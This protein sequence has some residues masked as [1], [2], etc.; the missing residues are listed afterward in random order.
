M[1]LVGVKAEV[2]IETKAN[3]NEAK[4]IKVKRQVS[5]RMRNCDIRI[6]QNRRSG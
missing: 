3:K 2:E 1:R 5:L 6:R 4:G